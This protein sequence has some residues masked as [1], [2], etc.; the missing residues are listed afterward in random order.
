[1]AKALRGVTVA[2]LAA[3]GFEQLELTRPMR[4]LARHGADVRVISLR[5]GRTRGMNLLWRGRRVTV[6]DTV[7]EANPADF[8]ALLLPG[9][10]ISPDLLR[11]SERA[12]EFVREIDR[13]GRPV[14]VICHGPEVLISADLVVGRRLTSWPAIA[15]DV[16][17]AGGLWEDAA[18]VRDDNWVSSRGPNDLPAFEKAMV[19]LF[20]ELAPRG[21]AVPRR[22]RW[23]SYLIRTAFVAGG[24]A[25]ARLALVRRRS[26]VRRRS[27]GELLSSASA[28]TSARPTQRLH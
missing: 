19:E 18:V 11:Q 28:N 16:S 13:R 3:D 17:N 15:D 14:A 9:G 25:G 21:L 2:V 5:P 23:V 27:R 24:V 20:D 6:D 22:S 10:F 8:G 26:A 4:T 1:M 12:L 7:F